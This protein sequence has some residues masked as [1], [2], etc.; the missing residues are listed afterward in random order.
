MSLVACNP[1]KQAYYGF[2]LFR[3]LVH[4]PCRPYLKNDVQYAVQQ[5]VV[6]A[7]QRTERHGLH[8][9]HTKEEV[10]A[11]RPALYEH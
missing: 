11:L 9:A 3:Q 2:R 8:A 5:R 7:C 10:M 4:V 1:A 6:A